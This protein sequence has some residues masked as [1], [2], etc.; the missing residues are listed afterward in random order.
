MQNARKGSPGRSGGGKYYRARARK[1][2]S[3]LEHI[4]LVD[5]FGRLTGF[6]NQRLM[7]YG[8]AK[9]LPADE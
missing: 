1:Y 9:V 2:F 4:S 5:L 3:P 8:S 7:Y 6:S